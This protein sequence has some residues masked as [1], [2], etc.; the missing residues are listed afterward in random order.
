MI[1]FYSEKYDENM[2]EVE[3][4]IYKCS[5]M[6]KEAMDK[7]EKGIFVS[8]EKLFIK[9]NNQLILSNEWEEKFGEIFCKI[10]IVI[11][12]TFYKVVRNLVPLDMENGLM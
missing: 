5:S 1:N 3:K 11:I 9:T 10:V 2:N 7:D 4:K 6:I 12:F 8:M